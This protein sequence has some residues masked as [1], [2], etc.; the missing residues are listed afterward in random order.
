MLSYKLF[1][2]IKQ[3]LSC[4]DVFAVADPEVHAETPCNFIQMPLLGIRL[5]NVIQS[6]VSPS[7]GC[8]IVCVG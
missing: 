7:P 4:L 8:A 5:L 3:S 6:F 2:V 1:R